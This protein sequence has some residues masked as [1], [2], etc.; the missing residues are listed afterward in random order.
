MPHPGRPAIGNCPHGESHR[1][2]QI[3]CK[4]NR[5]ESGDLR[6]DSWELKCLDCGLRRTI[7]YRSD[8]V[9][10]EVAGAE[11]VPDQCPFCQLDASGPG[12]NLCTK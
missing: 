1:S 10:E 12:K 3:T 4:Y 8:E 5:F 7:A 6:I 2:C 11:T 9:E